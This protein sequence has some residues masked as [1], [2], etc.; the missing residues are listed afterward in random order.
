M[1]YTLTLFSLLAFF[2]CQ[3][4]ANEPADI[5]QAAEKK[6]EINTQPMLE[7]LGL[8][9]VEM[10]MP[11]SEVIETSG[12]SIERGTVENGEGLFDVYKVRNN[13]GE[14]L[15]NLYYVEQEDGQEILFDIEITSPRI[16]TPEGVRVGDPLSKLRKY[17]EDIEITGSEIEGWTY[18]TVGNVAFRL[19][20]YNPDPQQVSV[21]ETDEILLI[22]L[23]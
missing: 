23:R 17:Y 20:A 12:A 2:A 4:P 8:G 10:R 7:A 22:T 3:G 19:Q 5:G 13:E 21:E 9:G 6:M 11:I 15:A 1:K 18:A 14:E 16:A